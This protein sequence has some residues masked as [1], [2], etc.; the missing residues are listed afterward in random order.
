MVVISN[1]MWLL[2]IVLQQDKRVKVGVNR[3]KEGGQEVISITIIR[4]G[5]KTRED[6]SILSTKGEE[7]I[8]RQ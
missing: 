6:I 7:D 2:Q 4:E 3:D 5:A 8:L 1:K